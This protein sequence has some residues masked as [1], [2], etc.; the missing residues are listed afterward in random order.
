M[1]III[2]ILALI[3]LSYIL[4]ERAFRIHRPT[5]AIHLTYGAEFA[6]V[7]FL[8]GPYVFDILTPELIDKLEPLIN[9]CLGWIGLM[10]GFQLRFKDLKLLPLSNYVVAGIESAITFAILL[11]VFLVTNMVFSPTLGYPSGGTAFAFVVAA[12]AIVSS[13]SIIAAV[14]KRNGAHG[15]ASRTLQYTSSFDNVLGLAA[16]GL[17]YPFFHY[18]QRVGDVPLP[19]WAWLIISLSVGLA[20][21]ALFHFFIKPR[22]T[23]NQNLMIAVGMVA[24]STGIAYEL[25]LSAL[26]INVTVG[27][28]LCNYSER[29]D[30]FYRLLI[31]AERPLYVILLILGGAL[32]NSSVLM[33]AL[34]AIFIVARALAKTVGGVAALAPHRSVIGH[35]HLFG[36][37]LLAQGGI[38]LAIAIDYRFLMPGESSSL[39]IALV[40]TTLALNGL[41]SPHTIKYLLRREGEIA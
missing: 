33:F 27:A 30:R 21:G 10:F 34:A 40:L 9:I 36:S 11:A 31:N 29:Y 32:W 28:V 4:S 6:V 14:I 38:A 17:V 8:L 26:F 7:G 18:M 5:L 39:L 1:D 35:P 2:L 20:L 25:H 3:L 24:F 23:S 41:I 19:G 15:R 22:A 13:P 37:A 12:I 16:F